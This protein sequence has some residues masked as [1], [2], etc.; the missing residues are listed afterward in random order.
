MI[1]REQE[2]ETAKSL[3]KAGVTTGA[4]DKFT[5]K[6]TK[7]ATAKILLVKW[8]VLNRLPFSAGESEHFRN[9]CNSLNPLIEIKVSGEYVRNKALEKA[10]EIRPIVNSMLKDEKVAITTDCWTS[11]ANH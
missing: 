9:F 10:A 4:M 3:L 6:T 11:L 2:E 7:E 5:V 1:K 8:I